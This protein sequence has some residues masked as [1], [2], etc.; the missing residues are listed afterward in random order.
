MTFRKLMQIGLLGI[1]VG[2]DLKENLEGITEDYQNTNT[3]IQVDF[4]PIIQTHINYRTTNFS[5]DTDEVILARMIFGEARNCSKEERIA[6]GYTTINRLK[7]PRKFGRT[8]SQVI[9]KPYQYSCFNRN[10]PNREKLMNPKR[11]DPQSFEE[12]LEIARGIISGTYKDPT[13]RATHYFNPRI[14]RP[15]WA[16]QMTRIGRINN[17]KHEFYRE[18]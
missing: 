18:D 2:C 6:V 11:Y 3:E 17:S 13:Q 5:Q 12:C 14:V 4:Q 7:Q 1:V 9:L 15:S 8:L 10:D 16:N